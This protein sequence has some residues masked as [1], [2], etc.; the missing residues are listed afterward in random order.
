VQLEP[1]STV[2]CVG[3]EAGVVADLVIDPRTSR[4]T[5]VVVKPRHDDAPARLV[6]I[7]L[8]ARGVAAGPEAGGR[9]SVVVL[10]CTGWEMNRLPQVL[11]TDVYVYQQRALAAEDRVDAARHEV[12]VAYRGAR[13]QVGFLRRAR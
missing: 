3:G 4:I 1:G 13:R 2:R 5:H 9:R 8:A 12:A 10:R 11:P 6:P 7:E